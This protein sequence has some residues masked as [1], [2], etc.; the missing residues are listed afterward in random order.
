[1]GKNNVFIIIKAFFLCFF[2]FFFFYPLALILFKSFSLAEGKNAINILFSNKKLI[3]NSFFQA[4][5]STFFCLLIGIP[6]GFLL[7]RR[8]F[9]GKKF[10]K[11][12]S[13]IPF[14]FPSILVVISFVIVFGNNGWIN[15]FLKNFLGF[16]S[17]VQFLYGFTGIIL[18]HTFYNFPLIMRFVSDSWENLDSTMKETA[19]SLGA[20]KFQVF[21]NITLRQLMPSIIAGASLVFI[22]CFMSF[23]IVISLGGIQFSTL[24]TEIFRQITRNLD[25]FTAG[26]LA[27]IQFIVLGLVGLIYFYYSKK[28][29]IKETGIK[30][31]PKKLS[32]NSFQGIM[33]TIYLIAIISFVVLPIIALIFFAFFNSE[34]GGFSLKAFGKIFFGTA[35]LS[36]TTPMLSVFYSLLLAV[37]TAGIASLMGL[38]ASLKQ[39]KI[40]LINFFIASSI[41]VSVITLAFGYFLGFGSGNF[42]VIALGHSILA[43]PFSFRILNNAL[44]K[45]DKESIDSAKT[46][47]ANNWQVFREV[48]LP[49]IKNALFVSIAFC[50]AV[51]LA[52]LGFVLVLYD[53]VYP[54]MP[55]YIYR[56]LGTFDLA[57]AAAMGLILIA[58]SFIA[59]YSIEVFSKNSRVF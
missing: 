28:Y 11:A 46:L 41:S 32:F 40:P 22:F 5:I 37:I 47:G 43:F 20:N 3:W 58:V 42:W 44:N 34:T 9:F 51:S 4:G 33:E 10:V 26:I 7:A 2:L 59:F 53:G 6:A 57:A 52:E 25:F 50:F 21:W 45:I 30:E 17:H 13:L 39:T 15:F 36:G 27:L 18:A 23:A 31:K 12:L 54:T 14:V 29:S 16:N 24:E 49:R 56:L 48:Q 38:L 55:V 35:S 19:K 8:D 1:M